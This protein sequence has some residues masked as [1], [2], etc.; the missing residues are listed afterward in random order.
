VDGKLLLK[1]FQLACKDAGIDFK[2]RNITFHGWRHFFSARLLDKTNA[3]KIMRVT[4]HKTRAVFDSY[5][6]HIEKENLLEIQSVTREVMGDIIPF[7]G[8]EPWA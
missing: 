5:S 2:A 6:D 8:E 7:T 3:E 4:G 1:N